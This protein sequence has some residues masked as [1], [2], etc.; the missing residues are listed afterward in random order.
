MIGLPGA[1]AELTQARR[2]QGL[3]QQDVADLCGVGQQEVSRWEAG[4]VTMKTL[5][6]WARA[7]GYQTFVA[8]LP[9][10]RES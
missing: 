7:L 8:V 2:D 10:G 5:D 1:V 3:R 9:K 6:R 4:Q